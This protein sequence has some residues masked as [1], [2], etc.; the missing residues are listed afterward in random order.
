M[1]AW[2]FEA[3][4]AGHTGATVTLVEGSSF[5]ISTTSGDITEGAAQGLFAHDTRILSCWQLEIDDQR[6][7]PLTS[8]NREP[9]WATFLSRA[10]RPGKSEST[11]LVERDRRVGTGM[12]EDLILH[13]LSDEP[14]SCTVTIAVD[15]D[16]A[17][18]FAVKEDRV[19]Y[20]GEH[21][22][23]ASDGQLRLDYEW[24][25]MRRGLSVRAPDATTVRDKEIVFRA[26]V[27]ARGRWQTTMLLLPVIDGRELSSQFGLR[28]EVDESQPVVRL[29]EWQRSSPVVQSQDE[30]L[31]EA[32]QQSR[33]DLG[34]LRIF[35]PDHPDTPVVA[36]GAPWFMALF[37]RDSLLT[38]WMAL[39]IDQSLALG[40]LATLAQH[41]GTK[42]DPT[43][44]E[45]PGRILHE[46][47]L[48]VDTGTAL[49]GKSIYYGTADA[50]PL[51]VVL[52][53]ELHEWGTPLDEL[54]PLVPHADRALEWVEKYGDRDG[55]GFVE[56]QRM[57]DQG[58]VNQGWK[59][60][61]DGIN[62][63]DGEIAR[64]PIALAEVQA[65]VYGA[66]R[67]RARLA[68]A[69]GDD[70]KARE[71][72]Q[73]ADELKRRFNEAFWVSDAGYFGIALDK[74]KRLVDSCASNMGHCLWMRIIDEDKAPAV[75]EAL[76]SRAMFNGWGIRTLST[77]MGAYNPMS[78]H[79][80]SVWPHD[81]ALVASGLMRYGF[82]DQAQG[83]AKGLLDAARAYAGRLP[84]LF[85]GFDRTAY[86]EPVPYP[87]SCSPQA[88]AAASPLQ[89]VRM[90]LRFDPDIPNGRAWLAPQWPK[91]FG[92][93]EV[94]NIPLAGTRVALYVDEDEFD[95][96]GL[97]EGIELIRE[98]RPATAEGP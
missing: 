39:P 53:G 1:T 92:R 86:P 70:A 11:L 19:R 14:V 50:T 6:P 35:D 55:D 22:A 40:T 46:V 41:Q 5:C 69:L 87:S 13:N 80:G 52:L 91:Q 60:S 12:R 97:P 21:E 73:K 45:Q 76:G 96:E 58:L 24:R 62:F 43:T 36:A 7:E 78:Y 4:P 90:L 38:S 31:N 98:P 59:D 64:S 56:Y 42:E 57:T 71:C 63:A 17:D 25:G 95:V 88:W 32:M 75:A 33:Q 54:E 72:D 9:F 79:N 81:S 67:S 44:E 10:H 18:L 66:Y 15:A 49:G 37:G 23:H 48:G 16:F 30:A 8:L 61:W 27:P 82:V 47:R 51:F 89:L 3:E 26:F 34:S 94:T 93:L 83:I 65:Y 77:Q 20:R 85:C 2:T 68:R 29:K 28:G 74:D 84:E